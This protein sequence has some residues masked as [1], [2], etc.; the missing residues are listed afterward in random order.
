MSVEIVKIKS[1]KKITHD[2]IRLHTEKPHQYT[3]I[4]GQATEVSVNKIGWQD[5]LRPFTFTSLPN[6]DYLEFIVKIYPNH[7]GVTNQLLHLESDDELILHDV[8]GAIVYQEEGIFIAGGAGITPF[9]SIF[10]SL[11]SKKQIGNNKLIFANKTE[12]DIILEKE[13][14]QLLGDNFVN[15]LSD[16]KSDRHK[17]GLITGDIIESMGG[18]LSSQFYVCGPPPMME[19]VLRQ[20]VNLGVDENSIIKEKI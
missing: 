19:S 6:E 1:R 16:E 14:A 15:V 2:V 20:I 11:A 10:R 18:N 3:F 12:G 17:Y 8:F 7:N 9:I 4:P 5:K 13:L